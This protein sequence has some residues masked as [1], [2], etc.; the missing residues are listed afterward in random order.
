MK[1]SKNEISERINK[2]GTIMSDLGCEQIRPLIF[3]HPDIGFDLDLTGTG[4]DKILIR[5][6]QIFSNRGFESYR[7][8][9]RGLLGIDG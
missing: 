2:I 7:Q 5:L 4:E 9:F 3:K 8:Q 6:L 1:P